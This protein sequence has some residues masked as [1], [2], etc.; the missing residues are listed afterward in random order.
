[1]L[2]F[3]VVATSAGVFG[4]DRPLVVG[5]HDKP[6]YAVRAEDGSWSGIA[7]ELW[8]RIA[9]KM[10][11]QFVYRELSF[12]DLV[13]ALAAGHI[14]LVIGELMVDPATERQIDFSQPFLITSLGVAVR[15]RHWQPNWGAVLVEMV[16]DDVVRVLGLIFV[17][18]L[19]VAGVV[20]W[21]ERRHRDSQFGGHPLRSFGDAIWFSAATLTSVGYGDHTPVT[22]VG[23]AIAFLWMLTSVLI[24]AAFTA[25]FA[26]SLAAASIHRTIVNPGDM[27]RLRTGALEGSNTSLRLAGLGVDLTP[28]ETIQ[29]GVQALRGRKI[30]AFVGDRISLGYVIQ[31]MDDERPHIELLPLSFNYRSIAFAMPN[32]SPMREELNIALLDVIGTMAWQQEMQRWLGAAWFELPGADAAP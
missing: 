3:C 24:I 20:W 26:A 23:R 22:F 28:F 30:D 7:I 6:P 1:V 25:G 16:S 13:P 14:D 32:N 8:E 19:V 29:D 10:D 31:H 21:V 4:S 11:V 12:G 18:M 17:G 27:H 15:E 2:I 9:T 5:L